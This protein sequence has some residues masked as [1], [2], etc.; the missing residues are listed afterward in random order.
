MEM[1]KLVSD[2]LKM[3]WKRKDDKLVDSDND[4]KY[5]LARRL[6]NKILDRR[7][8]KKIQKSVLLF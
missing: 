4:C 8:I 3:A 5:K 1:K 7:L 2:F 6:K